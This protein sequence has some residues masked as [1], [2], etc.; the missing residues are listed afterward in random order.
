M[1]ITLVGTT[2]KKINAGTGTGS[3]FN[4]V[5]QNAKDAIIDTEHVLMVFCSWRLSNSNKIICTSREDEQ[6]IQ[7][8]LSKLLDLTAKHLKIKKFNDVSIAFDLG[9]K[10]DVFCDSIVN[11]DPDFDSDWFISNSN[12]VT[13]SLNGIIEFEK[14]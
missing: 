13:S 14:K 12:G 9:Y 6:T 2:V 7:S 1:D 11:S 8:E 4:I 10:L 3:I 5:F